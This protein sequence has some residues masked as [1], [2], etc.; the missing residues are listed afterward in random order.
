MIIKTV[1]PIKSRGKRQRPLRSNLV[2]LLT[3]IREAACLNI[4]YDL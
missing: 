2:A 1:L 4:Q 3:L